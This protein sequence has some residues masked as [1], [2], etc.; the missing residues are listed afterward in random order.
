MPNS[1]HVSRVLS[2]GLLGRETGLPHL[3]VPNLLTGG[4][5]A[6]VVISGNIVLNTLSTRSTLALLQDQICIDSLSSWHV[7]QPSRTV[8]RDSFDSPSTQ[9]SG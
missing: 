2:V 5:R 6:D 7:P 3:L 4:K 8:L 9:W 1:T